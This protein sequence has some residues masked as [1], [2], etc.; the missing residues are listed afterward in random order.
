MKISTLSSPAEQTLLGAT[1]NSGRHLDA[2]V[3][4]DAVELLLVARPVMDQGFVEP[5]APF[6]C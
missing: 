6:H 2:L 5:S 3:R 4:F 1:E